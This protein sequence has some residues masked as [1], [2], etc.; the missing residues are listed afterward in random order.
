MRCI[1]VAILDEIAFQKLES[2]NQFPD[3]NNY[4]IFVLTKLK[5][6]GK[7][8]KFS[9]LVHKIWLSS[10]EK[11]KKRG[12][13]RSHAWKKIE[14]WHAL[15]YLCLLIFLLCYFRRTNAFAVRFNSQEQ[16]QVPLPHFPGSSERIHKIRMSRGYRRPFAAYTSNNR[17]FGDN[18]G[19]E[20]RSYELAPAFACIM[21]AFG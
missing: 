7:Q 12:A 14:N 13:K 2:L 4:L 3:F 21:S 6:E 18:C 15:Q 1:S 8:G 11:K 10:G 20:G 5:T 16:R 9:Q 17:D 19:S